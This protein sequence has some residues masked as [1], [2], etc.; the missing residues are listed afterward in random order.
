M[1]FLISKIFWTFMQP[2][3]LLLLTLVVAAL[4]AGIRPT[5]AR[6]LLRVSAIS[7]LLVTFLPIG[8][9]L[10]LPVERRFPELIDP[11][12]RI[13]GIVVLGGGLDVGPSLGRRHLELNE[14]AERLTASAALARRHPEAKVIYSGIKGR[15]VETADQAPDIAG[16][17][18]DYGI[19]RA[20]VLIEDASRNT[21]EN[22]LF[23]KD[24]AK[25]E[26]D[27]VW[28]LVTSAWHMPRSIGVFRQ[29]DWPVVAMPVD[30][31]RP[32]QIEL[33]D[34]LSL[35]A[36]PHVSD[37]LGELDEA[38]KAWVGLA[39]YWL[40]GRTSALFPGPSTGPGKA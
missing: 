31:R 17:Y 27:E 13:D 4:V 6:R 11:P 12:G 38:V 5:L 18:A 3:N 20:R 2:S 25:P 19:D 36:Q 16:F 34:Y 8:Q 15:L 1:S 7:L 30:F 10:I 35:I 40:M 39:A 24:M 32:R 21:L 22:A 37:R 23:S 33:N 28:V 29:L 9:W 14:G 26:P